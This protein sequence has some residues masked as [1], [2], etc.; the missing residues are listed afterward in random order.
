[1]IDANI[2]NLLKTAKAG[3][4]NWLRIH[5]KNGTEFE[6]YPDCWTYVTLGEDEDVE[7]LSFTLR[8]GIGRD[9]AGAEIE[10]FEVLEPRR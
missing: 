1:M 4:P 2:V 5:C 9:V 3:A 6:G 10:R 8:K 7:V